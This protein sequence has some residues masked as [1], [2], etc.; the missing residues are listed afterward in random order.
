MLSDEVFGM[1]KQHLIDMTY[2]DKAV[3]KEIKILNNLGD[4]RL[5]LNQEGDLNNHDPIQNC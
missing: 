5:L 3:N 2:F 4:T 1:G